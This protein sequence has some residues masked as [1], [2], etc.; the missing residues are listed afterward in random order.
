MW[1]VPDVVGLYLVRHDLRPGRHLVGPAAPRGLGPTPPA[2][3]TVSSDDRVP[4]VGDP[5]P[6][7]KTSTLA[8]HSIEEISSDDDPDPSLYQDVAR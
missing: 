7:V 2:A 6:A 8:D 3:F 5:A 1:T 4:G